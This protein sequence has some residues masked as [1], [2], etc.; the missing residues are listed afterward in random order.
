MIEHDV[1]LACEMAGLP[2][3]SPHKLRHGHVVYAMKLARN[4]AE[5]KAISQNVKHTSVTV[6]DQVYA[7]L[8]NKDT[9]NIIGHL[10]SG[11]T[12]LTTDKIDQLISMLQSLKS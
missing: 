5:L 8:T 1:R 4:M 9:K 7:R 3:L 10:G 11:S 2:Y 6:T 12:T